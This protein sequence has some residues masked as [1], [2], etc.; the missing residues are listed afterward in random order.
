MITS[1][2]SKEVYSNNWMKVREDR[3]EFPNGDE[4]IFGV[5]EKPDFVAIVPVDGDKRIH[6]V[7]QYRYAIGQR[8]WEIP[9]GAWEDQPDAPPE[10]VA[11]GELKEETGFTPGKITQ[12]G[13]I[14]QAPGYSSQGCHVFLATDLKAGTTEREASESDMITA[15]FSV[16]QLRAMIAKGEI[17]D[18]TTIAAFGYL[19]LSAEWGEMFAPA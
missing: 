11:L 4:G 15:G 13:H 10:T 5:V 3:V 6:L 17:K 18:A 14:F 2:G 19:M 8:S 1:H 7:Q 16:A 9:M 12:I